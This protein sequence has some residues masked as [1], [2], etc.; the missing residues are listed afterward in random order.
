M[1]DV[2]VR[3]R[4]LEE[5]GDKE[6]AEEELV[7]S[8]E[9]STAAPARARTSMSGLGIRVPI[10]AIDSA[11]A[12]LTSPTTTN[13]SR[14][15]RAAVERTGFP[16]L[17]SRPRERSTS[18]PKRDDVLCRCWDHGRNNIFPCTVLKVSPPLP[19]LAVPRG[20]VIPPR[21]RVAAFTGPNPMPAPPAPCSRARDSRLQVERRRR[22]MARPW[23]RCCIWRRARNNR[24]S[25]DELDT[26]I[27]APRGRGRR[28]S[29]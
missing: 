17:I 9:S 21:F 22:R 19:M 1:S 26:G 11:A 10:P 23:G 7:V 20:S 6:P 14:R 16:K 18:F 12:T 27:E 5:R 13:G 15:S 3:C 25:H 4:L 29:R 2:I 28:A 24:L 8:T